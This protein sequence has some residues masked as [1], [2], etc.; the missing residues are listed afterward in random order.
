MNELNEIQDVNLESTELMLS[1]EKI[2]EIKKEIAKIKSENPKIKAVFPIAVAGEEYDDKELYIAY[3]KQPSLPAFSKYMSFM[4]KD[5]VNATRTLAHDC[6]IC[7]DKALVEDDAL[8]MFGLM[9]QLPTIIK[10]RN[11]KL[12]NLSNIGK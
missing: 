5:L 11:A 1:D 9:S 3:F 6:F 12:V 7:G 8:F 10:S 2:E 4:Q